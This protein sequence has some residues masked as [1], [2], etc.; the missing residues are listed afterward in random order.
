[1]KKSSDV[2]YNMIL[3][4]VKDFIEQSGYPPSVREI[5]SALDIKSTSTVHGYLN[6]LNDEGIIHKDSSK[7]RALKVM[8]PDNKGIPVDDTGKYYNRKDL[9][10]VPVIGKV[11]AGLPLLAQENIEDTFPIPS[12]YTHHSDVFMLRI[13]GDS[14]TGAGIFDGDLVLVQ[15]Q[16]H[17]QNKDMV[18]A[19]IDDEATV[20]TFY[21]EQD[22]IRLQPENDVYAPIIVRDNLSILGKVIGVMRFF[23]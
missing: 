14:M 9:I 21:K 8:T 10:D 22:H 11:A 6:R 5:C 3:D 23:Q 20:K 4:F 2:K 12:A 1:M 18:V 7:R 17:A 16:N 13:K 15:K 19:L